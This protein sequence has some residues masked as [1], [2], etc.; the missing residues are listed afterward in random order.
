[1]R[2]TTTPDQISEVDRDAF[3][4]SIAVMLRHHE[5]IYRTDFKR[6]LED[7]KE[8]LSKIGRHAAS[9]CQCEVLGLKPWQQ[10]PCDVEPGETDAPGFEHRCT[11]NASL[12]L[13]RL[14]SA[15]LSRYEP[16]P[17]GALART[18]SASGNA[19]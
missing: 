10:A 12:I 17:I 19:L 16:D 13:E 11:R 15:G 18:P 8:P 3:E 6:R 14:L 2:P 1:M 9:V 4:R 5:R 7:A